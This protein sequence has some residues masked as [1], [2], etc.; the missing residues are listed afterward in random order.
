[1]RKKIMIS[2]PMNG[3]DFGSL[4]VE[5]HNYKSKL[6]DQDYCVINSLFKAQSTNLEYMNKYHWIFYK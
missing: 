3:K 6:T 5:Y 2:M 1:M 4:A